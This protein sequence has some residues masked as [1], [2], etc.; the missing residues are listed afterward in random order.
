VDF[1]VDIKAMLMNLL[2]IL[3]KNIGWMYVLPFQK[4]E[5]LINEKSSLGCYL[6]FSE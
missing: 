1:A 6:R 5:T 4:K 2:N 3:P